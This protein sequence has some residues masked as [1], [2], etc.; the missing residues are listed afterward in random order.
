MAQANFAVFP[1][2]LAGTIRWIN[3]Q[4]VL[5]TAIGIIRVT[6]SEASSSRISMS[7]FLALS[8]SL[9]I[10]DNHDNG[11]DEEVDSGAV[12]RYQMDAGTYVVLIPPFP[13]LNALFCS[14]LSHKLLFVLCFQFVAIKQKK[15]DR[16]KSYVGHISTSTPILISSILA[17]T[18]S[19]CVWQLHLN[20]ILRAKITARSIHWLFLGRR[21]DFEAANAVTVTPKKKDSSGRSEGKRQKA[22]S[23]SQ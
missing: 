8:L 11:V 16:L 3:S 6:G 2:L 23:S 9:R 4:D 18:P 1:A 20:S 19:H 13:P 7:L 22:V 14:L 5:G 17:H 15:P 21:S 10:H 12:S